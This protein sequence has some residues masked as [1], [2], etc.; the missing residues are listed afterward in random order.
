LAIV[1]PHPGQMRSKLQ[2]QNMEPNSKHGQPRHG[3]VHEMRGNHGARPTSE[4][5]HSG[6][7]QHAGHSVAMFR[8]K[9]WLSLTL[10]LPV[11][12]WSSEVQHWFGYHAPA[13][14]G[15]RLIPAILGTIVLVYGGSVFIQGAWREL[16]TTSQA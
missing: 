14:P 7:D 8:D 12:F 5:A 11:V 6:H 15:S 2:T 3:A 9:F 16:Q 4:H 10:T 13:F 1:V